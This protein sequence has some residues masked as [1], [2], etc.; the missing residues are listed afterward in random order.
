[1]NV[2]RFSQKSSLTALGQKRKLRVGNGVSEGK[3]RGLL[4]QLIPYLLFLHFPLCS[5][6]FS[7]LGGPCKGAGTPSSPAPLFPTVALWP[8]PKVGAQRMAGKA[9]HPF[10]LHC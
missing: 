2:S 9:A 8:L 10:S 4:S 1:M 7:K 5:S 3:E 6:F